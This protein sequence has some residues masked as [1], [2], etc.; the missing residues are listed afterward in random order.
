LDHCFMD[1]CIH[2]GNEAS[3]VTG[4]WAAVHTSEEQTKL[5]QKQKWEQPATSCLPDL[6]LLQLHFIDTSQLA[7]RE[8]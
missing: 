4:F 5:D 1:V 6:P 3:W 8:P 7:Q 2:G